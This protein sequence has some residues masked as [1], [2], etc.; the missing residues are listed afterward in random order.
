MS[1]SRDAMT[2]MA[3]RVAVLVITTLKSIILARYLLPEGRG[4]FAALLLIPQFMAILAPLGS[5]WSSVYYLRV[6]S[7]TK[8]AILQNGLGIAVSGGTLAFIIALGL[9][10]WLYD[11]LLQG[12]PLTAILIATLMIPI[13]TIDQFFRG[14]FRGTDRIPA[15]NLMNAT[16]PALILIGVV[17]AILLFHAGMFGLAMA[18]SGG[19]LIVVLVAG[20]WIYRDVAPRPRLQRATVQPLLSYGARVYAYTILLYVNYRIG[21]G[22]VRYY[23]DYQEVGYFVTSITMAELLWSVPATF[24]FVLFPR[25]AGADKARQNLLTT[26]VCRLT[27]AAVGIA[28]L[29]AAALVHPA[30]LILYGREFLPAAWP[31]IALLPGIF[32]MSV[33]QVLGADVSA[34]GYPGRITVAAAAGVIVNI[35]LNLWWIPIFGAVGAALAS[36]VAY[37]LITVI[38]L[39]SFLRLSKSSLGETLLIKANDIRDVWKRLRKLAGFTG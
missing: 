39:A 21:L 16:R 38:V 10:F 22:L 26:A 34:R 5:Q 4:Q 15:V 6:K 31:M 8:A 12:L 35:A 20:R 11:R 14:V 19:E 13:G 32:T 33:Q 23:L 36:S 25:I 24:A 27:V 29:V 3:S 28:C 30:I 7:H 17:A 37:T 1:M 18:F 2:T 9:E